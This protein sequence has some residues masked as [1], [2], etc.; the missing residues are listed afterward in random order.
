MDDLLGRMAYGTCSTRPEAAPAALAAIRARRDSSDAS[1][2]Q[3]RAHYY[4]VL[5]EG[6][7]AGRCDA[8]FSLF[9]R[10]G[11]WRVPTLFVERTMTLLQLG[12]TSVATDPRLTFMPATLRNEWREFA[13]SSARHFS[14]GERASFT[15]FLD[16]DLQLVGA[17]HRAG[18][19]LLAGT[20]EPGPFVMPGFALHDELALLVRAGLTPAEA[21]RAATLDPA[22]FLGATDSLGTVARGKIADLVLLDADPLLDVRNTTHIRAVVANGRLLDRAALDALLDAAK[23]GAPLD[24]AP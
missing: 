5:A 2:G 3:A 24:S 19:P 16:L 14:D 21:I 23:R 13:A 1:R 15:A 8:L 11:T 20:D 7:D 12:D 6:Y 18:V 10:R 22:R 17:M 4:R 9:R